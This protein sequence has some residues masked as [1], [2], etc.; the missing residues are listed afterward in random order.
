MSNTN[1]ADDKIQE[2]K[3]LDIVD[4]AKHYLP[5]LK[6]QGSGWKCKSPFSKEKT[7]SFTVVASKQIFKCF[8]TGKGGDVIELV[9][10]INNVTFAEACKLLADLANI[11]LGLTDAEV[12]QM[13]TKKTTK[14][15][16]A[17]KQSVSDQNLKKVQSYQKPNKIQHKPN[18]SV[19]EYFL[20]R[21]ISEQTLNN[22]KV[23]QSNHYFAQIGGETESIEFNY[24]KA[25]ELVNIKHRSLTK[26][27][28]GLEANC[29]LVLY[30]LDNIDKNSD[31]I[32][33]VEGEIDALT[34][35]EFYNGD[36]TNIL[37][38]PNGASTGRNQNLSYL[39]GDVSKVFDGKEIALIFDNDRAG[40]L[41]TDA[42][43]NRFGA[44]NCTV[45]TYPEDCKDVNDILV[46]YGTD[47]ISKFF[48]TLKH[49]KI[50][51]IVDVSDFEHE[52]DDYYENGYP[53]GDRIG[54]RDFDDL[55]SFRGGELTIVTG[56]PG[57]GKSEVLD[58]ISERLAVEH[59]WRFGVASME[60]PPKIHF[61]KIAEKYIGKPMVDLVDYETGEIK[62]SK[63]TQQEY[64]T[65]KSF[66][67]DNYKFI[68]HKTSKV[69]NNKHR[70]V[71]DMDYVLT[72]ARLLVQMY[73]I[74]GL[75][76]DPWN[77]LNHEIKKTETEAMYV[78]R[79]LSKLIAF[80]E[81]YNVHVFLVAHPTK[82]INNNGHVRVA[83]LYDVAGSADFF[84]KTHNGISVFR[85]KDYNKNPDNLVEIHVQ[86]IKFKFIGTIG[87]CKLK[88]DIKTGR[89]ETTDLDYPQQ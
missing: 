32:I 58:F 67:F 23:A 73:G 28:F 81:D 30:N 13:G 64:D 42:F 84:N 35:G 69:D 33:V 83:T 40:K 25:G 39:D 80:A 17:K 11:D 6:K 75:I 85:E 74:K 59:N 20:S 45:P 47:G 63:M 24:Y 82:G 88:Y 19:I 49:P 4:V 66:L 2:L 52:I 16:I 50:D 14:T 60:N 5:D 48:H 65:A 8:S 56:A 38:V 26:K 53:T 57:S 1:I 36:P 89:Y 27:A 78:G 87:E 55:I 54:L 10:E 18:K 9:K 34:I 68:T 44:H 21:G 77:T 51:G 12:K 43:V 7:P 79:I 71:F 22:F 62:V 46:N 76:I 86:K 61:G 41:L 70:D 31:W 29:E 3:Q 15:N 37:S 72:Q